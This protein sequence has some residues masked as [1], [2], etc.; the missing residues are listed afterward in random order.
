MKTWLAVFAMSISATA[1]PAAQQPQL[2]LG[3][4][5]RQVE[6]ERAEGRKASKSYTNKDLTADPNKRS[7]VDEAA[8]DGYV[9]ASTGEQVSPD[10]LVK[11]SE[12]KVA[13]TSGASMPEEHW[14][15]RADYLRHEFARAQER[16]NHLKGVP[17]PP[18]LPARARL[19]QEFAMIRQMV[20]GLTRQWDRLE[21]SARVARVP[22]DWLGERPTFEP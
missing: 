14:R 18:S 22:G 5:S 8:A 9:S 15:Q 20:A 16:N 1:M 17:Q 12:E 13:S 6:A 7:P 11:R 10:E 4:L 3:E 21:E 19:E 2:S